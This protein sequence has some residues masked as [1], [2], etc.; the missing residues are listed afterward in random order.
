MRLFSAAVQP[1]SRGSR[2]EGINNGSMISAYGMSHVGKVRSNNEDS[3]AAILELGLFVVADGMGGARA[4]EKASRI[5][6]ETVVSEMRRAGPQAA[7]QDLASAVQLA[8]QNIRREAEQHPQDSGMGT[9][10]VAALVR[11]PKAYIVNVGDSRGYLRSGEDLYCITSDNSWVNEIGRGLGLSEEQLRS[12]PYRNVLT[13]AV[14]AEDQV[15]ADTQEIHLHD[16]DLLLLCS[17]GLHGV[18]G[19][20]ALF[21]VLARDASLK[22]KCEALIA[23]ALD[24]GAPDN[25]TAVLIES[26]DH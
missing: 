13:K 25:I 19:E 14:G 17:D 12:H 9:T 1:L 6:V 21:D 10:I 5:A 24:R 16:G 11:E 2:F 23:A 18:A 20:N 3:F 15:E 22:E 7:P 4:G 8:N 26:R